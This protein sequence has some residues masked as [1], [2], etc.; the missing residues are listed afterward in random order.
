MPSR[1]SSQSSSESQKTS[2]IPAVTARVGSVRHNRTSVVTAAPARVSLVCSDRLVSPGCAVRC[3]VM[4]RPGQ[5]GRNFAVLLVFGDCGAGVVLA[6]P[7]SVKGEDIKSVREQDEELW[8]R[9]LG[10]DWRFLML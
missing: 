2:V 1:V 6:A 3:T 8:I 4:C 10:D 7:S 5:D 9:R